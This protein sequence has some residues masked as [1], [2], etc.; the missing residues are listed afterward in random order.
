MASNGTLE[1]SAI[2]NCISRFPSDLDH[3]RSSEEEDHLARSNKKV[4][5]NHG[6]SGEDKT[7]NL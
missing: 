2:A 5:S 7:E 3:E 6:N 4:K 1:S